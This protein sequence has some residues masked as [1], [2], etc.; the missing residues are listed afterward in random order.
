MLVDTAVQEN[1]SV[2]DFCR[3]IDGSKTESLDIL[4]ILL[5]RETGAFDRTLLTLS[6]LNFLLH[7]AIQAKNEDLIEL[8]SLALRLKES[9]SAGHYDV[10][11]LGLGRNPANLYYTNCLLLRIG[12]RVYSYRPITLMTTMQR[13][14]ERM[15]LIMKSA[16]GLSTLNSLL[17]TRVLV[18]LGPIW[19]LLTDT[20]A[21]SALRDMPCSHFASGELDID[22]VDLVYHRES[23]VGSVILLDAGLYKQGKPLIY[24]KDAALHDAIATGTISLGSD[25]ALKE[26]LF[27]YIVHNKKP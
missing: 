25:K 5:H 1:D 4:T 9:A 21:I 10:E 11:Y 22:T 2:L 20:P 3:T 16:Q 17:T 26:S 14:D 23:G 13:W 24:L 12:S 18:K 6:D 19:N 8:I 27:R 7:N 15:T